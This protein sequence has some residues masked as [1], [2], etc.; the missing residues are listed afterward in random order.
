MSFLLLDMM[1]KM[2][3]EKQRITHFIKKTYA[4]SLKKLLTSLLLSHANSSLQ[5]AICWGL[6]FKCN[7]LMDFFFFLFQEMHTAVNQISVKIL[8]AIK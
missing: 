4:P 8:T 1:T 2:H 3:N 5:Q 7:I 6:L